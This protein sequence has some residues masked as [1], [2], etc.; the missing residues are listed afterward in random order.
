MLFR[1][2]LPFDY[3]EAESLSD[4]VE[5][6]GGRKQKAAIMAGGISLIDQMKRR[7]QQPQAVVSLQRIKSLRFVKETKGSLKIGALA[8]LRDA[9]KSSLVSSKFPSLWDAIKQIGSVQVK[10][11]GTMVGNLAACN[12][13]SDVAT[14]LIAL[15]A[16]IKVV[17]KNGQRQFPLEKFAVGVRKNQLKKDEIVAEIVV[18]FQEEDASACF[19]NLARTKEDIAKVVVSVKVVRDGAQIKDARI[20]LGAVAPIIVRAAEA[21]AMLKGE[22]PTMQLVRAAA[23]AAADAKEVTPITDIR[24]T[25]EYR[26]E[27]VEVL[28]RRALVSALGADLN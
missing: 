24:S 21:E 16:E 22:K 1:K 13:A 6:L 27:M 19:M 7:M 2:L 18:P 10:T 26:K 20:V 28:T 8:T 11:M 14:A 4:A 9:E 5:I 25:A 17:G 3:L 23:R 15:G 12:P